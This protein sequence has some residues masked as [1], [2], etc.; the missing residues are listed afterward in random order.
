MYHGDVV[1]GFPA[2]PAPRVRDGDVR[3]AR[4][5]RPFRLARRGGPVRPRRRAVD[6]RRRG[7][8]HSEMFPLLDRDGPNPLELFQI[9]LNLPADDKLV[10]PYFTMLWGDDIPR[11]PSTDGGRAEITVDRRASSGARAAPRRRPTRGRRGPRPTSRSGTSASSPAPRG[12]SRR[13]RRR[14]RPDAVR[15]RGRG[16]R[17]GGARLAAATGALLRSRRR[18]SSSPAGGASRPRAP[19]PADRRAG[20]AVRAVR[21]E[22]RRRGSSRRSP[23]TGETGFGGWPWPADDPVHAGTQDRFAR[24]ADGRVEHAPD[25]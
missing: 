14:H 20:R 7:V 13:P 18:P 8:V 21:D 23:T 10:D 1:P 17:V 16:L 15:V 22:H 3:A 25:V 9:W 4:A 11:S 19:G 5:H 6:H 2:A 12:R 24:H